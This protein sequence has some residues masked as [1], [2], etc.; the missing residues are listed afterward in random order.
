[1]KRKNKPTKEDVVALQEFIKSFQ[2]S[3]TIRVPNEWEA[4]QWLSLHPQEW[5]SKKKWWQFWK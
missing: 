3:A 5:K 2:S 1:M 4:F